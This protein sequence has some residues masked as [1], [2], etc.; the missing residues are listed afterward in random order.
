MWFNDLVSGKNTA[1]AESE[2]AIW[3]DEAADVINGNILTLKFQVLD[4]APDGLAEVTVRFDDEKYVTYPQ[5]NLDELELAYAITIHKSQGSEYPA[6]VLPILSG[7]RP[8]MNRNILYTAVT[9]GK[10][11]VTIVGNKD[12]VREMIQNKSEQMRYSSLC[13]RLQELEQESLEK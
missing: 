3:I 12:T 8:L 6:V 9:R 10:K 11:C 13:R 4:N 7:P 1:D 5:G 2:K